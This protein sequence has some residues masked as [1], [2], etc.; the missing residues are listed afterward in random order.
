MKNINFVFFMGILTIFFFASCQKN[1]ADIHSGEKQELHDDHDGQH[2]D[3]E[4]EDDHKDEDD[5][6]DHEDEDGIHLTTEQVK[7]IGLEFGEMSKMKV[8]NF[9]KATG[10]L[11]LPP[12]AYAS[13]TAKTSGIV[14]GSKKYVEG[15]SI[16]KGAIIAFIENP[17]LIRQQQQYL[18]LKASLQRSRLELERQQQLVSANAGVQRSLENAQAEVDI[19]E[20]QQMGLRKQLS[21]LGISV[22]QLTSGNIRHRIPVYAPMS[23]YI[24]SVSLHNGLFAEANK[25]LMEII[26]DDHLHLELDIFEKDIAKVKIGQ[27]I[28]YVIPALGDKMYEGEVSIIGRE[29][30]INSKTVRVHGHL[31]GKRPT[32][33]KDLF[34]NAK[35]WLDDQSETALPA[36]AIIRDGESLCVYVSNPVA[37]NDEFEFE[38]IR[39]VTGATNNGFTAVKLLD[40]IPTG[41]KIVTKGAY[42]V[43]AQS[44]AGELEH[45]H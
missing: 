2:D 11:G 24:T 10:T 1:Q 26:S 39:V 12:N 30:N 17:D 41:K 8:N 42:Y 3:H 35:I 23:G 16:K 4:D 14:V 15:N 28:S 36:S 40:E 13:V 32:F 29:F 38:K 18:E 37:N 5:H 34:L 7:T 25:P 21:Y 33:F 45:E 31:H 19:L 43:Y 44:Q 9:V 20:A 6:D 22:D 27:S